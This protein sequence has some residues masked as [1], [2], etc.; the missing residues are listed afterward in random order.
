VLS[1]E[2]VRAAFF[3]WFNGRLV[4]Y[5][6]DSC[7]AAEFNVTPFLTGDRQQ[8]QISLQVYRWCDGSYLE[9]QDCWRLSGIYRSALVHLVPEWSIVDCSLKA[10][11]D[12]ACEHQGRLHV[13]VRIGNLE[14]LT[15]S[16]SNNPHPEL[17]ASQGCDTDKHSTLHAKL[18]VRV[19]DGDSKQLVAMAEKALEL[20]HCDN[21]FE[22]DAIVVPNVR[23]WSCEQPNLY[24]VIVELLALESE[25]SLHCVEETIGFRY[26]AIANDRYNRSTH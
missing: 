15:D 22:L 12:L 11:L 2:G 21:T 18:R 9:D 26:A 13:S 6:Q 24:D 20:T 25:P 7:T 14:R 5:S 17:F 8:Q 23:A 19:A 10:S 1:F 3:V 16:E 4:G